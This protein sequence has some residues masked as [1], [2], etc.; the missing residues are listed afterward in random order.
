MSCLGC[1]EVDVEDVVATTSLRG[2]WAS[3]LAMAGSIV[4]GVAVDDVAGDEGCVWEKSLV[5]RQHFP[6]PSPREEANSNGWS[7]SRCMDIGGRGD[8]S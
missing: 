8:Q 2:G 7:Y 4:A 5:S 3:L 1:I 6:S